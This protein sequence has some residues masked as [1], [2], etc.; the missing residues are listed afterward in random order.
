[1]DTLTAGAK[2]L[3]TKMMVTMVS[4]W[5]GR[6]CLSTLSFPVRQAVF[7][8]FP[9]GLPDL[10]PLGVKLSLEVIILLI[11]IFIP[12]VNVLVIFVVIKASFMQY[13]SYQ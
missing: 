13:A 9:D 4:K 3:Q 8:G 10:T 12:I 2:A 5:N 1:M 7:D 11:N 6:H